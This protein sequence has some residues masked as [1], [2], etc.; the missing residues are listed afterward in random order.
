M[1][2]AHIPAGRA[3]D[4]P[5]DE[6][7]QMNQAVYEEIHAALPGQRLPTCPHPHLSLGPSSP[8]IVWKFLLPRPLSFLSFLQNQWCAFSDPSPLH[9][10]PF[11]PSPAMLSRRLSLAPLP[12]TRAPSPSTWLSRKEHWTGSPTGFPPNLSLASSLAAEPWAEN[13]VPEPLGFLFHDPCPR[14]GT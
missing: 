4:K 3:K 10:C 14:L 7:R 8:H 11:L 2:T 6:Q 13:V 9:A 12:H 1:G 5:V